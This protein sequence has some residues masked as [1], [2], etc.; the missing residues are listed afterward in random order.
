MPHS[1]STSRFPCRQSYHDSFEKEIH[2]WTFPQAGVA[3][4]RRFLLYGVQQAHDDC[5]DPE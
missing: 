5:A 2:N 1:H 4:F 3:M